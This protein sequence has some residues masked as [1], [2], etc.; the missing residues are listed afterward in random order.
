[1][2]RFGCILPE[3]TVWGEVLTVPRPDAAKPAGA[4]CRPCPRTVAIRCFRSEAMVKCLPFDPVLP[5]C[6][7]CFVTYV[8]WYVG[9]LVTSYRIPAY[10][11]AGLTGQG[12]SLSSVKAVCEPLKAST[13][14]SLIPLRG[15][16]PEYLYHKAFHGAHNMRTRPL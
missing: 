12:V 10:R 5:L 16:G 2:T 11:S 8:R 13:G 4:V 14:S 1:M 9:T 3:S 15:N 7:W 6:S